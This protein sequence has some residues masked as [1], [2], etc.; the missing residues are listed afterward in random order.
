LACAFALGLCAAASPVRAGEPVPDV[1]IILDEIP[2]GI[3]A[4]TKTDRNGNYAFARVRP[5][6]YR[7]V[8]SSPAIGQAGG[9]GARS[10]ENHNSSRSNRSQYAA[11]GGGKEATRL[12]ITLLPQVK[13]GRDPG[14]TIAIGPNHSGII[15]GTV[16]GE[17]LPRAR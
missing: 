1:D 16:Q 2:G 13:P 14:T 11:P 17:G 4:T 7:I 6:N 9:G 12:D 15:T 8:V 10:A 3:V 5:G